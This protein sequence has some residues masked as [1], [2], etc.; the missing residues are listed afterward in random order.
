MISGVQRGVIHDIW[1]M[2]CAERGDTLYLVYMGFRV[3][4]C[5]KSGVCGVQGGVV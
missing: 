2:W 1:C 3:G 5:M 4:W